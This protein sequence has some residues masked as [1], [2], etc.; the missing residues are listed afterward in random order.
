M[1]VSIAGKAAL[2]SAAWIHCAREQ[3]DGIPDV[4]HGEAQFG[5]H[6]CSL[7]N[8]IALAVPPAKQ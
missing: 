4:S 1:I 3:R 8:I 5:V 7:C 2:M 6:R